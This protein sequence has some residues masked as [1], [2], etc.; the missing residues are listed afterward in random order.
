MATATGPD[1][2]TL[3][4]HPRG[5]FVIAGTEVWD[6]I[7]FHGMQALLTLYLARELLLPGHV[8]HVVGFQI[9]RHAIEEITGPLGVK[10]LATQV[11]GLYVGFIY[12][13]PAIG[14]LIGDRFLGRRV[15]IILGGLLMTAGHFSMAFDS[16][17]LLAMLFLILG[18]GLFRGNLQPQVGE[19]YEREDRRRSIAFQIYGAAVNLGALIAPLV[20]GVLGKYY[21]W[22]IGFGFAGL[23]MLVGVV[24]YTLGGRELPGRRPAGASGVS[25]EPLTRAQWRTILFLLALVPVA[26]LFW[27][28]QSQIWNTYNLWVGDH[29]E[30]HIFG[31]EMPIPWL[32]SLDGFAPFIT[33]PPVLWLWH[34]Q[35]SK[36]REPNEFVK[37]A[38]GCFIFAVSTW[39]LGLAGW[40]A[41]AHGRAPLLWA[42][43]FHFVSNVGWLYFAPTMTALFSRYAPPA[44]NAT[45]IGVYS[46]SVTLGSLISGRLGALYERV[47]PGT[48]WTIHAAL[49]GL[50]G[51]MLLAFGLAAQR[52]SRAISSTAATPAAADA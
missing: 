20:T 4:G 52:T 33:L 34:W 9:F 36:G 13:M 12:M 8:E 25:Q 27:V 49:A 44:V 23:G 10:A 39:W 17:F 1:T 46:L 37:A 35:A 18:A 48:F 5:L 7:S 50:G 19:L 11:F 14:G 29:I 15:S 24:I 38:I 21:G 42:V 51:I 28:A 45:M 2:R 47:S 22:H 26:S 31:W 3:F 32:Q 16:S 41:D 40:A 6:R 43:V 30:L